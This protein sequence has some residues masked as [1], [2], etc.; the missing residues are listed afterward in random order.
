MELARSEG[1]LD[2]LNT[3]FALGSPYNIWMGVLGA[4]IFVLFTHG[5]DQLVA[6]RVLACRSIADGRKALA[7]CAAVIL[8]MMLLF[9]MVGVLLWA[10]YQQTP[11]PKIRWA[12]NKKIMSFLSLCWLK[13]RQG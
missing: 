8:P 3:D 11:I 6:Q 9:L 7:F 12:K 5:I 13:P 1:K 4:G 2:W 10:H